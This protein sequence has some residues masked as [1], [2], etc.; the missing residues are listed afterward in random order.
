MLVHKGL[1]NRSRLTQTAMRS[2]DAETLAALQSGGTD[3]DI[4]DE[5]GVSAGTVCNVRN[6]RHDMTRLNWLRLGERFGP[7]ALD[8]VLSL[9]G[10]RA[11]DR[12]AVTVDVSKVP[13][14]VAK[15]L[16]L[17]IELFADGECSE[18]DVR[19]LDR[20]GAIDCLTSVADMLRNRRDELRTGEP[21]LRVAK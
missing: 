12:E 17:L 13:C 16:P 4:A 18:A 15:V 6:K 11:V 3:Q 10:A 21:A 14:D 9:I 8:P 2:A 7:A 5:W 19:Q 20:S 1:R